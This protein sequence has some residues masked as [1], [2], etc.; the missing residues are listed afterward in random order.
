MSLLYS[1][2]LYSAPASMEQQAATMSR[3][4]ES[5]QMLV[6]MSFNFSFCAN[7]NPKKPIKYA[8]SRPPMMMPTIS[9]IN[10]DFLISYFNTFPIMENPPYFC[11]RCGM[12]VLFFC[13]KL[14]NGSVRINFPIQV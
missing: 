3:T 1:R 14:W 4:V 8:I 12:M 9:I 10:L 13:L 11:K 2:T 5:A 6:K 7:L